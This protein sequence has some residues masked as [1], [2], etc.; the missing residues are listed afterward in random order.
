V[1]PIVTAKAADATAI[2]AAKASSRNAT[3]LLLSSPFTSQTQKSQSKK[4]C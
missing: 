2:T 1:R 3:F 4:H